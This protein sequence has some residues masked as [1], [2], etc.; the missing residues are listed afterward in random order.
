MR[1]GIL[2]GIS[3]AAVAAIAAGPFSGLP[4]YAARPGAA[5][6]GSVR[7]DAAAADRAGPLLAWGDNQ[8]GELGD[9]TVMSE[10]VPIAVNP[11]HDLRVVSARAVAFAV[12]VTASG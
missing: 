6:P 1:S 3:A 2:R 9:G 12:A 8:F 10:S 7:P 4:A 11:P 5:R